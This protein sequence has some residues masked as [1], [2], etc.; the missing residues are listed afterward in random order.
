MANSVT[1]A[2]TWSN[3]LS[4][5]AAQVGEKID[6]AASELKERASEFGRFAAQTMDET[7]ESTAATLKSTADS[8]RSCGHISSQTM[9]DVAGRTAEK[10][11]STANYV[12]DHDFRGMFGDIGRAIRR[13]PTPALIGAVGLGFLLGSA[14]MR[15]RD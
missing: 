10:I 9:T 4:N 11:E 13:N 5:G 6:A 7:R 15:G 12:R 14:L 8:V 2:D 1:D 3:N